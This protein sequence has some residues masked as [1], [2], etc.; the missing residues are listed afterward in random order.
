L[1]VK[2]ALLVHRSSSILERKG[3]GGLIIASSKQPMRLSKE[4]ELLIIPW[5]H[6]DLLLQSVYKDPKV[7]GALLAHRSSSILARKWER[8]QMDTHRGGCELNKVYQKK[9]HYIYRKLLFQNCKPRFNRESKREKRERQRPV[10]QVGET[11]RINLPQ[12]KNKFDKRLIKWSKEIF[13][14]QKVI[15]AKPTEP[16]SNKRYIVNGHMYSGFQLQYVNM[17]KLVQM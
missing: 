3:I 8:I 9:H 7:T 10:F 13:P 17:N 1:R 5:E 4:N 12:G 2:G 15:E 11:V 16:W 14:V 6:I